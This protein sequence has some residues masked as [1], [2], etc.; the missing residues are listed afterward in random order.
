MKMA[1][2]LTTSA[3]EI[4]KTQ[5]LKTE[6]LFVARYV[7]LRLNRILAVLFIAITG[8]MHDVILRDTRKTQFL[9]M[10]TN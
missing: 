3:H 5:Y 7:N 6:F 8:C 2:S 9:R 4:N 1:P 10:K